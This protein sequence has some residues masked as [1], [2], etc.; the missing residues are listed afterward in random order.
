MKITNISND[1][2][3]LKVFSGRFQLTKLHYDFNQNIEDLK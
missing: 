3:S 1:I 2:I